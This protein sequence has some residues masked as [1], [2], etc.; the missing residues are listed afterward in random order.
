MGLLLDKRQEKKLQK[1][2]MKI[3]CRVPRALRSG[4]IHSSWRACS[5]K[6]WFIERPL[7]EQGNWQAPISSPT[8][9][10]KHR[11]TCGNQ[12]SADISYLSCFH[13][14]L[15]PPRVR[16]WSILSPPYLPQSQYNMPQ[17]PQNQPKHLNIPHIST[18]GFFSV[19]VSAVVVT[20]I[21]S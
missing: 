8:T 1:H 11:T 12:W 2:S 7:W 18:P 19:S 16:W 20:G 4:V 10:H 21:N 13:Q 9:Q 5:R 15:P 6:T 14:V 3:I 17:P